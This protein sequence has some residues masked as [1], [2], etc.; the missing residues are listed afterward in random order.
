MLS[1]ELIFREVYDPE[2]KSLKFTP[3]A[4]NFQIDLDD[5]SDSVVASCRAMTLDEAHGG[6]ICTKFS[7]FALYGEGQVSISPDLVGDLWYN[8]AVTEFTPK[9]LCAIRIKIIGPGKLVLRS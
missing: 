7:E 2:T 4:T 1:K 9:A 5:D 8:I 3:T 6:I